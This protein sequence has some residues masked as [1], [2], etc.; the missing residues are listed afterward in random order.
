VI[1]EPRT[2]SRGRVRDESPVAADRTGGPDGNARLTAASATLLLVLLALEGMTLL[3]MRSLLS[4]H[5]FVGVLL[6]PPAAVKLGSTGWR[7]LR[8]YTGHGSYVDKGPPAPLMRFLVAPVVVASTVG[9]FASVIAL[10]AF[11]PRYPL[12]L[13][14]HKASFAVW[15][16]AMSVHVLAYVLRL[17][18]LVAADFAR[19]ERLPGGAARRWLLAGSLVAGLTLALAT[20]PLA[21]VGAWHHWHELH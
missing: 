15:F 12:V 19:E 14:L 6:V 13:G 1:A 17:P 9:L 11:G 4:V 18:G 5:V 20:L 2:S 16:V 7:F 3:A 21:H 10:I 8:Y